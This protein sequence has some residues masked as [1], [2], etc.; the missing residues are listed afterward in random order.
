M[1]NFEASRKGSGAT[2]AA[3]EFVVT[4]EEMRAGGFVPAHVEKE[5]L[6][7]CAKN[8]YEP[9]V[10]AKYVLECQYM[11]FQKGMRVKVSAYV[12]K[13]SGERT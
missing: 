6:V 2:L 8:G 9:M 10:N 12:K 13:Q 11:L 3:A 4:D 7:E 5:F 1:A